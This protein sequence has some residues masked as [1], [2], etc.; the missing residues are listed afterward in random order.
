MFRRYEW[1]MMN[2]EGHD[3]VGMVIRGDMFVAGSFFQ[4]NQSHKVTYVT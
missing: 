3:I 1:K 4:R 2:M